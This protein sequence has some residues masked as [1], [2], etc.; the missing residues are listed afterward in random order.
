[1]KK[2]IILYVVF[3]SSLFTYAQYEIDLGGVITTCSGTFLDSGGASGNYG[4]NEHYEITFCPDTPGTYIQFDFSY[5]DIE[6]FFES[7]SFYEGTGTGGTFIGSF[8][9]LDDIQPCSGGFMASSH[10]SGCITVAFD[11]DSS[12]NYSGWEADISCV[13]TPGGDT[14]NSGI[15]D[16]SVCSGAGPFCA[17]AGVLEFPNTSDGD[18]VPDAPY[19]VVDNSCLLSAPNPA[20]YYVEI[21]VSGEIVIEIEQTT[22]PGGTGAGLDVD[23]VVW[24]PFTDPAS[25]CVDFASGDC[26]GDHNCYG[27]VVDCSY[28]IAAVE[29]ATIP[30]AVV[31][32][33]YMFLVTNY[34]GDSGYITLSQTNQGN[35]GAGST[36]CCPSI[37]GTD[38]SSCGSSDGEIEISL[39]LPNTSYVITYN[40]P[41]PQSINIISN[42]LGEIHI[43]NLSA[44][45]YTNID[46]GTPGCTPRDL[47]L[48]S[49]GTEIIPAFT[50][51]PD[52]C[53]G[54]TLAALPTTSDNGINGTWSPA[55][56]NT[57][58]TTYTFTPDAGEC[59]STQTMTITVN[60]EIV[61]AFTQVP[62]ICSG[63]TLAALPTT[64]NNGINGTWNP[65][66]DNTITTTYTFTPDAGECASTQTM[67]ITV[68]PEVVPTFTQVP[69]ICSGDA[70]AALPT[71]SDNGINGTWS[72]ALDNTTTTAYTFTPDAG[73]CA[74]AQTMTITV[75]PE[76]VPAFT[77]VPDICSGE[78]LAA[79][80][81]TSN[82]GID[83][84]W[85]PAL[86][87]TT[88]TTYT[89][90]PDAGE[91]A[92]AQA[93]TITV[94]PEIVPTFTQVPDICSGDTLAA[95]PTTS[96]NGINGTWSPALDNTT[97]TTY[98]FTPDAG[99]CAST[100]T[101][102]ITVNPE[103]VPTFMQVPEICSGDTLAALPTT[104][105]NGING[106]WS[107]ALDNTTTTTYTFTP[108][109]GECASTQ[110][111]TITVNP[112]VVPTFMQVPDIC[113][114]ETLA[115]LPTTSDN[116][117]NGT[118]SPSLDNTTTTTYTFTPNAGEC[119]STQ[120]MT[121][122]V[123]PEIVPT[124]TQVPDICSG[125]TIAP[126]PTTS[127][128]GISGTWSP[129]LDNTTTTTYT[130]TPDVGECASTQTMTITVNPE[131]VPTFTQVP[132]ICSGDTIAALPTTSGN[133]INGTWSP[134]LDNTATTTYTF[135]PD[136]GECATAQTMT[137]TVN[138][139][140][141]PT[142]TQVSDIC[143]GDTLVALPT[144][145]DNGIS[146]TWSPAL[147]NTTTTTYTFTPD[148]GECAS[149]QAMTITVNPEIVPT[150][151]QVPDICSGDTL[152]A[153]PTTSGNGINGTWSPALD[154]TTTTTYTFTPDAGECATTQTMTITVNPEV[155]PTFTQVPDICSGD[156]LAALPTTS[157]NGINGTWSP[158]LD[159]TATTTYT[160][161]PD[162]G[163]CATT[164]TMTIT[165]N[166]EVVPV[167]TQVP[168]IC[169][170]DTLVAL[171][172]TS[173]NGINGTW[174]PA[175]DNTTTTMYTF[176]PDVGE[177]AST[178]TMTITVNSE[179]IP[180]FTQVPD[181]CSGD[182][183]AV[184]PTTSDN[185]IN[186][187][188][189]PALDNTTT[190]T[191]TFTPNAGECA[192]TQTMTITVNPEVVPTFTQVPDICSGDTLAALPTTSN[193]GINGTWSPVLDNTTTTTYTF[194]PDAGECA[195]TQTMT[196]TVNP[197][198]VPTFTQV[199]DIC[200]GDTLTALPATSG[201][202]INGTWSPALDNTT[203][204]TYTFTPDAGECAT[205]QTMTITVNPEVVPTFTQVPD[206]CSGDT[207]AALPTTSDNGINGTWSPALDNTATTT[208]TFTPDAGECATTQTM[209]ITV[210]SVVT[211]N[212]TQVAEICSGDT[213]AALPTT[214][215]NGINGTWSPA[216]N[217]TA[218][219]TYTFTPDAGECAT[220]QTMTITVH[221]EITPTFTQVA[222]ICSGD[223]LTAL[224]TTSNNGINGTW[225][226][227]LD[228][229]TTTTYTFTPEAGVCASEQT[230]TITVN[231][232]V[233][234]AFT[235]VA[236]I[237]Y[238]DTL[239][240]LPTT[241]NNGIDGTW[242][243]ALDNTTTTTY[244]FTPDAGEC[245]STQT[246]TI[247]VNP[248]IVP[249]FTQVPSICS[250]DTL[251]AL[252]TT[253]DNGIS[254]T[255]SPAL[256]NTTTT[257]YTFTPDAGE[258]ATT[259]TMTITVNPEIVPTFT[260]VP[261]ICS[262]DT[263]TALPTTSDNGINGTWSPALDNTTTTTYTFTPNA[264][265]CASTQTMTITVNSEVVPTFTQVPEICSGDTLAALPTTSNNGINGTWSPALD[266]TTT[267][268]YTFT[269]NAGECA[270]T[271]T[272]TIA[273]GHVV[274]T[275][276]QVP[277]ICSGDTLTALPAT[278]G[279]G[280][281][282]TWS[283]MLDNTTTTTYTF[284]PDA[285]ECASTQ[286]MTITVN[287][288][289]VPTFTQV[290]EICSGDTLA[291]LPTTSNNGINGAWSPALDNTT[292][293]TYTFM[294]NA[295]ECA[296]TQTM[297]IAVGH[298][299]PTFTQVPG[300][301]SGDTLVALPTTSDNGIN[302]TWS[303]VLDNTTTTTYTFTPD[304]GECASTQTMT[305]TVNPEVVP[306]FT[307]V[308]DICSG[309]TLTALPT[310]SDN[311]INGTWSPALDNTTTTTY[312]F[313][314]DAGEC[315]STQT[316]TITVNPEIVPTFTQVPDICSGDTLPALPTISDNGI[317]GSWSPALDNTITTTYTFTP[318]AGECASTQ[319]MTITVNPAV[320][321]AFTQVPGICS[322]DTLVALPTTSDNGINGTWSP[323]L[324]NTTTTTYTFTPNA[325][326]CASTQTMTITVNTEVVPTFT[327]VPD[328][329][330]GDTLA[331]LPATSDNGINGTWSPA[332]D[333]TTTTAYTFTPD[334]GEC[335]TTQ[336]MTIMVNSV[337]TP[338]FTQVAEI[339]SGDTLAALPTTSDNGI[340][341]T[342]SPVLNNTAT[343][344]Y[345]FTP[346]AGECA[347]AQTM[348]ITVHPEITP[349]FTQVV[350]ICSGD[351]LTALPTTSNNGINGTWSPA[352]DNTTTTTYTFTPEAGVCASEQTMTIT[353]NP[354][355][356]PA[357]TQVAEIC[358]G[359]TLTALP[360]TSNNGIDGTWSPALDNTM[361]T[362]Y[363]FTPNAGICATT[364]T[365]TIA[366]NSL[367]VLNLDDS[368][369]LC[370]DGANVIDPPVITTGLDEL[371]YSYEWFLD[372]VLIIGE[373]GSSLVPVQAGVYSVVVTNVMTGCSTVVGDVDTI[374]VVIESGSP[375]LEVHTITPDFANTHTIEAIAT[376]GGDYEFSLDN[377]S[378]VNNL[379]DANSYIF[380]DVSP[381]VHTVEVRDINGCGDDQKEILVLDYPLFFTPNNDGYND[382]W[383]ILGLGNQPD[384]KIY[385]FDRY[386]KLLKQ[387]SP[388]S[389]GWDGTFNGQPMPASDYW[390]LLQ[391]RGVNDLVGAS[392]KEFKAHFSLKR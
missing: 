102:T 392:R 221:P 83:G 310:T 333:N 193:N 128:N 81:T 29:T 234:P 84:T 62:D 211:P 171:P 354:Q 381:G 181:I 28:S 341:G 191:Y 89:F 52:I 164:Q 31:G 69:D 121:I 269:P 388:T 272:M 256:D 114:G 145:S 99:E 284:T 27:T 111:M 204:T 58:T 80:P 364:Q 323:V 247:T 355:V 241:S 76:I 144:I 186:G 4:N 242:N 311:G 391:Y 34:N 55:L 350:A 337:V 65:A 236:E 167:F 361:T 134:A 146:G 246:M 88:T 47:V 363:T 349:T 176:T 273:V 135:T 73:E 227:S 32:E 340:N 304:A 212:F 225:S 375:L 179:V 307:Q 200:S 302:G 86:D 198:V 42:A 67:T 290:P 228:N 329:C 82:N 358:Y 151:T 199:P 286:T 344:T 174:S 196:I 213:L 357:F 206:I 202:G 10:S 63:D 78:T 299:V 366:V 66:L 49:S 8:D 172:I 261:D 12:F 96:G 130:F 147:D 197:A 266:N 385:I 207:L 219:T 173:D 157:D 64:S 390:F 294:P 208:Y 257:T 53:S 210:N 339:C 351:T 2:T 387:L 98:T 203:T 383:Q 264:G 54:D 379:P 237:C 15:P 220:A 113:S 218:T 214:S 277:D 285:G 90:T 298:V 336:T 195:S 367:P 74:T 235:Q 106:T 325:G 117:I 283:P 353:V 262:G 17:D 115:P 85:S 103:V 25:A 59:A 259:Q 37:M 331:P 374:T 275:F 205:T 30:N 46:T 260:Q 370:M 45:S 318:D 189:S 274:P 93:M 265:E 108:D 71:T 280:I 21:G 152:A 287:P 70:L 72:P 209:T 320:V 158:A 371:N 150:F 238:G 122:T 244:T 217:N 22:G 14:G 365:M 161:T 309:D 245:A 347:T 215:N 1:M 251:T 149:A 165:V 77:Q 169:S 317:N 321:P 376:G 303:P 308:L 254:G 141:V 301:C 132:D 342:W 143:S 61:P 271:Q 79:L 170:G 192:S 35:S 293:T 156:T 183:L 23:Y 125:D 229:T 136:V 109:A 124:F 316:M 92:S 248:E 270:T 278:S 182:T 252:P 276:T 296:T 26:Y 48:N 222:A 116:G 148:A 313:T 159:N 282:G 11:S 95:L 324:D 230:M 224:P 75:N 389:L 373:T 249:T 38:P 334:A 332:L 300:I 330:S 180:A 253:S 43:T 384:A 137:I 126:L 3:L 223:A 322:G 226:P 178:Q 129:A 314:P 24:G 127:D 233:V 345:T 140:V 168:D 315:A 319:T 7:L 338:S 267:T 94:N 13:S 291:A 232:Q 292:T 123:N 18:C 39:L 243:P 185:G 295:G 231:P 91:C 5:L 97:T 258:C 133:G 33:F 281:S 240:A 356:V 56:D 372:G 187:T 155:V 250:G 288:E 328:I 104:S 139:E 9:D 326:E 162:A 44:G 105:D 255:W 377:G 306:T 41:A 142:F 131:V 359:D 380:T 184:L 190:T 120:T 154:N 346:D 279:N 177:C 335:A 112:E 382:T 194:T 312:T 268:T 305:I 201:N 51:V 107:P 50:Q 68:N 119:A 87:N 160:F 216:L 386:G 239:T 16:N 60:L 263:L 100:Q 19:A 153:L 138:P 101:M 352:L 40:D 57:T 343:T 368:Y 20:W 378:W 327:Q 163:E 289:I 362:T 188:W 297:T 36:D 369:V 110:T 118:W 348:T 175:L 166:P 360:T 6:S